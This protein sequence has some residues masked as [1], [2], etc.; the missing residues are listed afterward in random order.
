MLKRISEFMR[1][2]WN[3]KMD[4][5]VYWELLDVFFSSSKRTLTSLL[6]KKYNKLN[7]LK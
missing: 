7:V 1:D 3:I 5:I 4:K 2:H 6:R